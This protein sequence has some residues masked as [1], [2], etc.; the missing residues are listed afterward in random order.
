[1]DEPLAAGSP[2]ATAA[3]TA[4]DAPWPLRVLSENLKRYFERAP[5]AWIEGQLIEFKVIRG[6]A[7]MT[8]RDLDADYSLPVTAWRNVAATLDGTVEQGSRVVACVKPSFYTK[9]GKLSMIASAMR[10]VGLGDLLAR[11]EKLRRALEAEGLFSPERKKPLPVLPQLIGLVTGRDSDAMKDVM[12]NTHLRWPAARFEV[13]EVAVQ[14][15]N[16]PREVMAAVAEL[17]AH[18]EVDVIVIA[19]GG[20]ALEEVVLPFS[21]ESLVRAVAGTQT[22]VVS[23][24]GH[25]ADR[26]VLDDVADLR[27]S[28]P[29][30]AA[31]RIVPDAAVERE[32]I[33]GA[34]SRLAS[35]VERLVLHEAQQLQSLRTRPV[36]ANPER[37]MS[38]RTDD[39]ER[40]RER[41]R[42]SLA[43]Q[44][45]RE[46]DAVGHL[47][48]RV[49]S[50]S[51]QHTLD[52]GYAVVQHGGRVVR[53]A[54]QVSPGD[55]LDILVAA[56]RIAA[57]TTGTTLGP[58]S[59]AQSSTEETR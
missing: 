52:R 45:D 51:P 28:T 40:W 21:D 42:T 7:W 49:R 56:G 54:G 15:A 37:M 57:T 35:G 41:A 43:G 53:D 4:P 6:N 20:G 17:D 12:R 24:I 44:L 1:M 47:R 58:E 46:H 26:P 22:P 5:Q 34:R 11:V 10:P 2:P 38:E 36:L 59:S 27:A 14:G 16:A 32:A 55:A 8:L 18:P 25:E 31:K 33:A 19:R 39:L 30:D 29:T 23:A 3:E 50:L 9:T 48:A 13:R